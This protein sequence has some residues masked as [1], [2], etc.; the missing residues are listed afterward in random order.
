MIAKGILKI[1]DF[2]VKLRPMIITWHGGN[3]YRAE[4][5]DFN[6]IFDPESSAKAGRLKND[7][8]LRTSA[9]PPF[10]SGREEIIGPGEYEIGP[11]KIRGVAVSAGKT[12]LRTA[13]QVVLQ[14]IA[15]GFLSGEEFS[16]SESL[17]ESLGEIDILFVPLSQRAAELVRVIEPKII[18]P[19]SG[20][21]KKVAAI[22]G[23]ESRPQEK[24]VIKKKE[25]EEKEG[26]QVIILS[27]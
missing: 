2:F 13:Y 16:P 25:L 7:L 9:K 18:I 8:V 19:N 22:F 4:T 17:L 3:C 26:S 23:Q 21:A 5:P 24:L 1:K 6:L 27:D 14:E 15:L 20:E 10:S 12:D 11:A